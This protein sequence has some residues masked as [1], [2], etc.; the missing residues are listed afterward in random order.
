MQYE[1]ELRR[2]EPAAPTLPH[3][4]QQQLQQSMLGGGKQRQQAADGGTL[5]T[6]TYARLLVG[7][8]HDDALL[9]HKPLHLE[10]FPTPLQAG[11]GRGVEQGLG[12][13]QGGEQG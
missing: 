13:K 2:E 4:Q 10:S 8:P 11:G 1:L 7:T 9:L 12:A 6:S 5:A 3:Q